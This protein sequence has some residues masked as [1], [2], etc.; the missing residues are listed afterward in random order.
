MPNKMLKR[1]RDKL[2]AAKPAELGDKPWA[3]FC[4]TRKQWK[5][6]KMWKKAGVSEEKMTKLLLS[7]DHETIRNL[8]DHAEAEAL[9]ESIF[10]SVE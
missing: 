5:R 9:V 8:K 4:W 6:S 7:L 3:V 1:T 10:G 2:R